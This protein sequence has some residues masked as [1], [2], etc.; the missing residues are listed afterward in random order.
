MSK[1]I[2]FIVILIILL[3]TTIFVLKCEWEEKPI[4]IEKE[5]LIFNQTL[6]LPEECFLDEA[7]DMDEDGIID[8]NDTY[9]VV[10]KDQD[11][12]SEY[13]KTDQDLDGNPE[14][15]VKDMNDNQ[16]LECHWMDLNDDGHPTFFKLDLNEDEQNEL[17]W[18]DENDDGNA[19]FLAEDQDG[20]GIPDYTWQDPNDDGEAEREWDWKVNSGKK[21]AVIAG[22][23]SWHHNVSF[24]WFHVGEGG[25]RANAWDNY[26]TE[27][28]GGTD[29]PFKRNPDNVYFPEGFTPKENPFYTASLYDDLQEKGRPSNAKLIPWAWDAAEGVSLMKNRW[30]EV[31]YND[32][33]C[34]AQIQDT[35]PYA[36]FE[37]MFEEE[38]HDYMGFDLS[39]A[40]F[41]CLDV[42]LDEG[43][44]RG[45]WR[46]VDDRDVPDGPW[47]EVVT[48]SQVCWE[49][50]VGK[51][52]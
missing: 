3:I 2:I 26:W 36:S 17:V 21:E 23:Y 41:Y 6:I 7:K 48:T 46:F 25:E 11:E 42:P 52:D 51:C 16:I 15:L 38:T 50:D 9:I 39:P 27:H 4:V 12:T 37:N 14:Y 24:P 44:F 8:S 30:V 5:G 20:N 28:F 43:R 13:H 35:G 29:W 31:K 33:S 49:D 45:S 32:K 1:K 47:K 10:N 40:M 19:E 34:F 18:L 22:P